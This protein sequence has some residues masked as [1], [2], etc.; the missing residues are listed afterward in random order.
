MDLFSAVLSTK[1]KKT[2]ALRPSDPH[3]FVTAGEA[4][5][6]HAKSTGHAAGTSI[7]CQVNKAS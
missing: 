6:S 2:C 1:L 4:H 7:S 5:L 3:C